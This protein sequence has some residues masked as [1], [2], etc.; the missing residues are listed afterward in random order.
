MELIDVVSTVLDLS[1]KGTYTTHI[2][3]LLIFNIGSEYNEEIAN[4]NMTV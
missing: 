4:L 3:H 2:I 1:N